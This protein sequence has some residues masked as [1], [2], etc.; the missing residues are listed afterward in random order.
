MEIIEDEM[1]KMNVLEIIEEIIDLT[2]SEGLDTEVKKGK[3]EVVSSAQPQILALMERLGLQEQ[4]EALFLAVFVD[5]SSDSRINYNDIARHFEVRAVKIL[6]L[7]QYI[8]NLVHR[9]IIM[10]K[11]DRDGDVTYRLPTKTIDSLREGHL[12][13]PVSI[14]NLTA[15]DFYEAVDRLLGQ[16]END[17]IEDEDLVENIKELMEHN[18]Q[19][20]L[21]SRL[22]SFDLQAKNLIL[23]LVFCRCFVNDNDDHICRSDLRDYFPSGMLRRHVTEL[24]EGTHV[25]MKQKLVEHTFEDGRANTEVWR[26]TDYSKREVLSELNLKVSRDN[27]TG[28]T[29][30]EDITPKELFYNEAVT[31]QVDSLQALLGKERMQRVQQ[32]LKDKGMRT[33]FTCLFYGAPG[34]GKTETVQQLARLTGRDIMLVDVPNIRS[35]WV[36]ETEKNIKEVF[37]RY[38]RLAVS[39]E[40]A[41][42][43]LFNEADAVLG[44]R[45]E[46]ATDSVDKMENAMQNIILQEMEQMEGI[47]IAT[48]NLTGSLDAAFERRFLYKIEFEKPSPEERRHIWKAMLPELSDDNALALAKAYDFSGGQIENI[49][50]KQLIDSVLN[51]DESLNIEA[52]HEACRTESLGKSGAKRI[53]F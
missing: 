15:E 24:T 30:H 23:Y 12:P 46:G 33:G 51:E 21:T 22:R 29:H 34:T 40:V 6:A 27:R 39:N 31:R 9:G 18:P 45:A 1:K 19:L 53:G 25:L 28:L 10:R 50:R 41:P 17:E 11:K 4:L 43:L 14:D 49:A 32:R 20:E 7:T 36:G 3:V 44:R 37:E 2:A 47:M 26:L 13:E 5:Q 48:T 38:H 16:R 35:K 52:V 42:I 8:D